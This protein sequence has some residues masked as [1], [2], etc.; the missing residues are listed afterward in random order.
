MISE[1][2]VE[3]VRR[4]LHQIERDM[5]VRVIYAVE[6]G[7]R[8]YGFAS[9]DSDYDVRGIYVQP[10]DF[11]MSIDVENKSD[12]IERQPYKDIDIALW[13]VR[14]ALQLMGKSNPHLHEWLR[15]HFSLIYLQT[16][17][18]RLISR[19]KLVCDFY[20]PK[21][22]AFHYLHMARGNYEKYIK[23]KDAIRLKKY[24]YVIRPLLFLGVLEEGVTDHRDLIP[25]IDDLISYGIHYGYAAGVS[26]EIKDIVER[27]RAGDELGKSRPILHL[28]EWIDSYLEYFE[29]TPDL[30]PGSNGNVKDLNKTFR[31][32]VAGGA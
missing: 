20:S 3:G 5:G 8:S 19:D 17:E 25:D 29:T 31:M 6:S 2:K 27:K 32:I 9:E 7:S 26:N 13:D 21:R 1:E 12:T 23:D 14:K 16:P 28:N 18:S 11:Y 22:M 24:L 30:L 10:P 4:F 15:S